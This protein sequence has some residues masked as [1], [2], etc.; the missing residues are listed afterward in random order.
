MVQMSGQVEGWLGATY[1]FGNHLR[2]LK[3]APE[4]DRYAVWRIVHNQ[5]VECRRACGG[6]AGSAPVQEAT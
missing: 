3:V 5:N 6:L 4:S 1:Q 2:A